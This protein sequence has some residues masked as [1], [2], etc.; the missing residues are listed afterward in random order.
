MLMFLIPGVILYRSPHLLQSL[1]SV[2]TEPSVSAPDARYQSQSQINPQASQSS[3]VAAARQ[4]EPVMPR[5]SAHEEPVESADMRESDRAESLIKPRTLADLLP[6]QQSP[7][8]EDL[9]RLQLELDSQKWIA[10]LEVSDGAIQLAASTWG[11][12]RE[13]LHLA[14]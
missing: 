11:L 7:S 5:R 6:T 8:A 10:P 12:L 3:R 9:I 2:G 13:S 14:R 1:T 4:G